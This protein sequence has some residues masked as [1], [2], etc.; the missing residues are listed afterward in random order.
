MKA[1]ID[2][3]DFG[4]PADWRR[5]SRGFASPPRDGFAVI[6]PVA[7]SE[8]AR[9]ADGK[10]RRQLSVRYGVYAL[11]P[12]ADWSRLGGRLVNSRPHRLPIDGPTPQCLRW[13]L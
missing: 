13:Q 11:D 8:P 1:N 5:Q 3:P 4:N 9:D 7:L 12:M 10:G 2:P 6:D